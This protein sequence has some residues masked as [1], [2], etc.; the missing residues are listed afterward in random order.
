MPQHSPAHPR[1]TPACPPKLPQKHWVAHATQ[2]PFTKANIGAAVPTSGL[3]VLNPGLGPAG[4]TN[5]V[6]PPPPSPP[7]APETPAPPCTAA[8]GQCCLDGMQFDACATSTGAGLPITHFYRTS[9]GRL[10]VGIL[11][12]GAATSNWL[13]W[14]YNPDWQ[15]H[16]VG[17]DAYFVRPCASCATKSSPVAF[18]MPS[19]S[20]GSFV[21][22]RLVNFSGRT[23]GVVGSD[24][25]ATFSLPV[26]TNATLKV[27]VGT[28]PYSGAD[29]ASAAGMQLHTAIPPTACVRV[30][31]GAPT[32]TFTGC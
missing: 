18:N 20:V 5:G 8:N 15:G 31:N 10:H 24:L 4:P 23:S 22:P 17:A 2:V 21:P 25:F 14:S 12:A 26:A 13:A 9:G 27:N 3:L 7:P 11:G 1:Q 30:V 29:P 32:V 28:G 6:A 16:M 19:T